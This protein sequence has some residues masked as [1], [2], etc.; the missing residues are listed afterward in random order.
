MIKNTEADF[1]EYLCRLQNRGSAF[2]SARSIR[3]C[4]AQTAQVSEELIDDERD[5][6]LYAQGVRECLL[7][8]YKLLYD[9]IHC[10]GSD[11]FLSDIC[12]SAVLC[13]SSYH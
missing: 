10:V 5:E 3:Q 4:V 7:Y 9:H 6:R 2:V 8:A 12:S 1:C 11:Y 13:S